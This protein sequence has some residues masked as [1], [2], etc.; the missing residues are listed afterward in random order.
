MESLIHL[1]YSNHISSSRLSIF[2]DVN[3]YQKAMLTNGLNQMSILEEDENLLKL[4]EILKKSQKNAG[5]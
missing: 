3:L 2:G 5:N 1:S 4:E